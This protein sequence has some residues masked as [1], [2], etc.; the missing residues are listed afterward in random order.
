[1]KMRV[2]EE[3]MVRIRE[4]FEFACEAHAGQ[5]RKSGESY[6]IHP[7]AVACIVAQRPLPVGE[8][9]LP[10]LLHLGQCRSAQV[11]KSRLLRKIERG[12]RNIYN[13]YIA[14]SR[15]HGRQVKSIL[16]I[17]YPA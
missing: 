11:L 15:W 16:F 8:R 17:T 2:S 3:G 12:D 10:A 9:D 6:I 7:I 4:A 5:K 1:M 13:D 14:F